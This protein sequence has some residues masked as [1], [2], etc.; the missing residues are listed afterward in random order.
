MIGRFNPRKRGPVFFCLNFL[1]GEEFDLPINYFFSNFDI[2]IIIITVWITLIFDKTRNQR[3][4]N[5]L[6]IFNFLPS[7][8]VSISRNNKFLLSFYIINQ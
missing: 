8:L 2:I 7:P 4:R 3:A 5:I 6:L 1:T